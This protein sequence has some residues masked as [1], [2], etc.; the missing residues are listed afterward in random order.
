MSFL[1]RYLHR[2]AVRFVRWNEQRIGAAK[3]IKWLLRYVFP[4]HWSFLLG[5]I[6]L[7]SFM[8]LVAS[9]IYLSLYYVP[10]DS[11]VI[12]HGPYTL[13]AGEQIIISILDGFRPS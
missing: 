2:R 1:R 11:Q 4:D 5:E 7:Y 9:G 6:A 13:L 12:Y 3:G 8:V 10:G